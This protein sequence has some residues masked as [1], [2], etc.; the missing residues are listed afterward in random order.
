MLTKD[1]VKAF[2]EQ[3]NMVEKGDHILIGFSGGADSV[4]LFYILQ[5]LEKEYELTLTAV[6]VEHGI[7]GEEALR[8]ASFVEELCKKEGVPCFIEYVDVPA[9]AKDAGLSEEEMGRKIRY[10][11]FERKAEQVGANKIAVAH[12]KN[13][14]AETMLFNLCRG[15]G[16]AGMCA[17]SPVRGNLIRPL[18]ALDRE[19]VEEYLRERQ[20]KYCQDSTNED[21][22]YSRNY[23]RKEILPRLKMVNPKV[24]EHMVQAS[25]MLEGAQDTLKDIIKELEDKHV[26][27]ENDGAGVKAALFEEKSDYLISGVLH[28]VMGRLAGSRKD[29]QWIH[30]NSVHQLSNMQVGKKITLPYQLVAIKEYNG[31]LVKKITGE[32]P[33]K[34]EAE[35]AISLKIPGKTVLWDDLVV[36]TRIFS[37]E[38]IKDMDKIPD[39]SCTKWFD[40]DIIK[41]G[42]SVR[43]RQSG[44]YMVVNDNGGKKKL[45]DLLINEKVP[46]Q[47]RDGIL[48]F[49]QEHLV[50]WA[51][52]VRMGEYG[53]IHANTK[54]VL[55][56]KI[57]GGKKDE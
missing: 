57:H 49:A 28:N 22:K 4:C 36:E 31:I 50:L 47:D 10:E 43:Y 54:Q 46:R 29:I 3:Q 34:E 15:T 25:E 7:R 52:G 39:K 17:L 19:E 42:I 30:I 48:I 14:V 40:Y 33:E 12:H 1:K 13:D 51:A 5:S 44:D 37:A 20:L 23:L 24:I 16:L 32:E 35:P 41:K 56:I 21:T 45:K 2:M 9:L 27:Y 8:D 6:H 38:E 18:L 26:T 55:E 53:K 11:L